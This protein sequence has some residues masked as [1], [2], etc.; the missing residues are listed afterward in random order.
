MSWFIKSPFGRDEDPVEHMVKLLSEKAEKEGTPLTDSD[1]AI[2]VKERSDVEPV[3]EEL[4]HRA[5]ELIARMFIEEPWDEFAGDPKSF[6]SSLQWAGDSGYPN[7]V[8]LT[9]E[10]AC[11]TRGEAFPPFQGWKLAK[12]RMQLIG[13]GVLAV[14]FMFAI[15]IGAGFLFG[16]K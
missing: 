12:D 1:R 8:S 4:R 13:C 2:L 14:L 7:I 11:E 6:G 16:W 9:E 15:V 10:V 3:P 5:K